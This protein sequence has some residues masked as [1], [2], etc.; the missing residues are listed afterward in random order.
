MRRYTLV[1]KIPSEVPASR[2]IK[3][4]GLQTASVACFDDTKLFRAA[5]NL[6]MPA[7][8]RPSA[9]LPSMTAPDST[10][11]R[12]PHPSLKIEGPASLL[13]MSRPGALEVLKNRH[14]KYSRRPPS[15]TGIPAP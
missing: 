12:L 14:D 8:A 9:R 6:A 5:T 3:A 4:L 2:A 1:I 11:Q 13:T 15:A 10:H 7:A